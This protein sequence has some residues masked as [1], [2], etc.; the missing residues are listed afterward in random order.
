MCLPC[1]DA[2]KLVGGVSAVTVTDALAETDPTVAVTR[3]LP[4][5]VVL[6]V[7][8]VV[9]EP[10]VGDTEPGA[11]VDQEALETSTG[12]PYW[13]APAALNRRP[14]PRTSVALVGETVIVARAAA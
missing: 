3:P 13:S 10:V 8:V 4:V 2:V 12:L 11:V 1:A 6:A 7:K 9:D 5:C 14:P